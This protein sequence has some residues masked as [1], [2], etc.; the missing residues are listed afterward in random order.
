MKLRNIAVAALALAAFAAGA[1]PVMVSLVTPVQFPS[2]DCDIAGFGLSF[3]YGESRNFTG[4]KIGVVQRAAGAFDGVGVGGVNIAGG[5]IRG[6]QVGLVNWN[7]HEDAAWENRSSGA[8]IGLVNYAGAFCG[9]QY[10]LLNVNKG[11]FTG[12]QDGMV[13]CTDDVTGFQIAYVNVA[14]GRVRGGQLG[15][16]NFADTMECGLQVGIV[17]IIAHNGWLPVLPL[18]N[19]HF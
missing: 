8:Q 16:L 15:L 17:N 3:I 7:C 9:L 13:N 1:E 5:R 10:G 14:S 2:R 4:L 11:P 18:V 12:C 6:G 19:G